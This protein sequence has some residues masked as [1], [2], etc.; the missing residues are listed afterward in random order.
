MSNVAAFAKKHNL[1]EEHAKI[2]LKQQ[3]AEAKKTEASKK[4]VAKHKH[5]I[6]STLTYDE[7]AKKK[8]VQITCQKCGDKNRWVYTSDLH[9]VQYCTKCKKEVKAAKRKE[10]A[11]QTKAALEAY[12]KSTSK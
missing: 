7:S 12:R 6:L 2:V 8:K 10:K 3:E 4:K 1:S 11:E 5:A 9:Q